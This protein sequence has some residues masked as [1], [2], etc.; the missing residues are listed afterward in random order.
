M[1]IIVAKNVN[2]SFYY[3]SGKEEPRKSD[4]CGVLFYKN[5]VMNKII[6]YSELYFTQYSAYTKFSVQN[7]TLHFKGRKMDC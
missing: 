2:Y 3:L 7:Y 6:K 4:R 5:I 1:T